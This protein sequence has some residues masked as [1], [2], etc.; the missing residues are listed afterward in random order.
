MDSMDELEPFLSLGLAAAAGLLIGLERERS[1]P[2]EEKDSFIGGAR[3]HPLFAL[4]GGVAALLARGLGPWALLVPLVALVAFLVVNY[5]A[6]VA[7]DRGRGITSEAA[8]L[9]SFL[10]GALACTDGI[11][12]PDR[13]RVF[14]VSAVAVLATFLLSSK[15]TT[16]RLAR[17]LTREDVA[18]TLKFLVV[19]V[20][21]L[22][23]LPDRTFGPLDVLNPFDVGRLMVLIAALSFV[24][25]AGIRLLGPQRGLGLTGVV[26]GLVSSTAVTLSMSGRARERPEVAG[27]AALA[28]VLASTIMFLRILAI[29]AVVNPALPGLL[30][31]PMAGA[32]LA[33]FCASLVLWLRS[34]HGAHEGAAVV[35]TNP[36]EL[37][38]AL[39]FALL[40]AVVLLGS[41]AAALYL[42]TAGTYA[43][44]VVAGSTDVDAITLS[45]SR[46][47]GAQVTPQVAATTIFL[48]AAS[49]TL[50]KGAMAA[51]IGGW[52][53][54]RKVLAALGAM[55]AAGAGGVALSRVL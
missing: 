27:A 29:V 43:A 1:A 14:V 50:V 25:Y 2:E 24:G 13:R 6:D 38:R 53:F 22:P 42:G 54:G 35:F 16:M 40:F 15:P 52:P 49:N 11:V 37:G 39:Q 3:T 19:A 8:F 5:Q 31:W 32:A 46:L 51:V 33:G 7:R 12:E 23:L 9:L 36:F 18:S 48:G 4:V 41:K 44:G 26:G 21:V 47:A 30:A 28:V 34:R 10:L 45:M 20:I 17:A 55:L